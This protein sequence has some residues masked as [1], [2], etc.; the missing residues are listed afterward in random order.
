MNI[1]F[2]CTGN[3]C[4]SPMAEGLMR[5]ILQDAGC[6]D[7]QVRSAGVAAFPGDCA[8]EN[9]VLAAAELGADISA[10]RSSRLSAQLLNATDLAVC[11]T[12]QHQSA[13]LQYAPNAKTAVL[14]GG[15]PDPFG[16]DLDAYRACAA[17][18]LRGVEALYHEIAGK[19]ESP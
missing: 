14:G 19:D 4:R 1:S 8:S 18:I 6:A 16:Q 7:I 5:K 11:M 9:A 2:L 3:T 12:A 13:V 17:A 10:H 15:I